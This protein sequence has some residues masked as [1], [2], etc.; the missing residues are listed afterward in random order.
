[1]FCPA[2]PTFSNLEIHDEKTDFIAGVD[3]SVDDTNG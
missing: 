1:M 3:R 2:F